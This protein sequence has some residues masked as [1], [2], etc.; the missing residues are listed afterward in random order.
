MRKK[1]DSKSSLISEESLFALLI[2][3]DSL[4]LALRERPKISEEHILITISE[5]RVFRVFV[6]RGHQKPAVKQRGR[7]NKGP[8]DIAPKSF[9]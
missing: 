8:P 7:E 9:S 1:A 3:E 2:N 6:Y 5:E 4:A